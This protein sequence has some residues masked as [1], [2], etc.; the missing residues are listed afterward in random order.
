MKRAAVPSIL[1]A[2]TL[3]AVAVIA[4]AQQPEKV[5]RIGYLR[6][7]LPPL[8]RLATRLSG[9]ACESLGTSKERI[10]SLSTGGRRENSIGY[11]SLRLS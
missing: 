1:V 11:P 4:E 3:L 2:V 9:K 6:S 7:V 5:T 8:V 10:L